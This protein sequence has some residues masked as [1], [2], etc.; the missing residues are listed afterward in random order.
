[1]DGRANNGG[2]RPN[3]V[4]STKPD[5]APQPQQKNTAYMKEWRALVANLP[6]DI[7]RQIDSSMLHH[8][9]LIRIEIEDLSKAIKKMPGDMK[10]RQARRAAIREFSN[11]SSRFGMSPTDRQR[12]APVEQKNEE[13]EVGELEALR[14]A[15]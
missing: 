1:M 2:N 13:D 3:R 8:A 14:V 4:D 9:V 7:L 15:S 5:G 12:M 10:I 11:I 6:A